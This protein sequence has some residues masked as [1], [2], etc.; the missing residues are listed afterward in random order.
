MTTGIEKTHEMSAQPWGIRA[1]LG[2]S[3]LI[4]LAFTL[5]QFIV[6]YSLLVIDNP[7]SNWGFG[8]PFNT[9]NTYYG[10]YLSMAQVFAAPVACGLIIF[11]ASLR[12]SMALREYLHLRPVAWKTLGFWLGLTVL[13]MLFMESL[14]YALDRPIPEFMFHMYETAVFLPL[15]WVA[16]VIAAPI[17]EE[18]FF[19]GFFFESVRYSRLG[20][21]AGKY[22]GSAETTPFSKIHLGTFFT[23]LI[24]ALIWA[25]IHGQYETFELLMIFFFGILLGYAR[26]LTESVY[27]P[28]AMHFLMNFVA[29]VQMAFVT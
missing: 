6:I 23:I 26:V 29:S 17:L 25:I 8:P 4:F 24:T 1:T 16:V 12:K 18:L 11:F 20:R 2:F 9:F 21:F 19:R 27:T 22:F 28:M 15:L 13:F 5:I 14:N 10:Y 3:F 7:E